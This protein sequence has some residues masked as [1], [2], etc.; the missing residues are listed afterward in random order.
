MCHVYCVYRG[1]SPCS[2]DD[3]SGLASYLSPPQYRIHSI[4]GVQR[5]LAV[6]FLDGA[7]HAQRSRV[8]LD[9][10]HVSSRRASR[11][12]HLFV[13]TVRL[14]GNTSGNEMRKNPEGTLKITMLTFSAR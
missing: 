12:G 5:R 6:V 10:G 3:S 14:R 7:R 13:D 4:F 2:R 1:R 8:R 11:I 9:A